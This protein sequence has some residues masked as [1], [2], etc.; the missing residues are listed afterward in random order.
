MDGSIRIMFD[1]N[2]PAPAVSHIEL[3][4]DGVW[5]D[6][7]FRFSS[8]SVFLG[9]DMILSAVSGFIETRNPSATVG[10][11]RSL[12]PHIQFGN[13]G[14]TEPA[15]MPVLDILKTFAV[16]PG[17]TV[18]DINSTTIG[19]IISS[20]PS[21]VLKTSEHQVGSSI[22]ATAPIQVSFYVGTDNTG[23]LFNRF[24]LPTSSMA[25]LGA[26][27]IIDFKEDFGF[28]GGSS[29]FQEFKS[30]NLISLAINGSGD[31]LTSHTGHELKEIDIVLDDQILN[32]ANEFVF[33]GID[34]MGQL[35]WI[36]NN[37]FP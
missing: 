14:T 33:H 13:Q 31:V 26:P 9:R 2:D 25:T 28:E 37:R 11:I 30:D 27:L 1:D 24:N 7:G 29:I 4:E 20:A 18:G 19:Q 23:F 15:D 3:L 21:R 22:P 10:H 35:G 5:N 16:F 17:P 32:N 12:I 36:S 8:A 34:D 6:T